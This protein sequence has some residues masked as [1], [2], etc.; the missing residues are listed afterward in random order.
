MNCSGG[1]TAKIIAR[2]ASRSPS[3]CAQK[4][5]HED[6]EERAPRQAGERQ[7]DAP[8]AEEMEVAG[9]RVTARRAQPRT[10]GKEERIGSR[11]DAK[12]A[13]PRKHAVGVD[14][15]ERERKVER[16]PQQHA[17]RY[18]RDAEPR[19]AAG[20]IRGR[21]QTSSA[22]PSDTECTHPTRNATSSR[23][24]PRSASK[25]LDELLRVPDDDRA[26]SKARRRSGAARVPNRAPLR[27]LRRKECRRRVPLLP[28]GGL[29]R[30]Y[31]PPAI[32]ALAMRGEFLTAYT[33]YQA[34]VSQG[35]L[36]AI[37]EWQTYICSAHR[38]GSRQRLG[39]RRRDRA[40]RSGDHGARRDRPQ[41]GSRLARDPSELSR[42]AENVLRR[43]R[44]RRRRAA[45]HRGRHDRPGRTRRQRSADKEYAA[46]ALQSPNFFGNVDTP[47]KRDARSNRRERHDSDRRRRR[48]ALARRA[49]AAVGVGRAD[50]RR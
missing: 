24:S 18:Q 50:R 12:R 31:A 27:S 49:R 29:V 3:S 16:R 43:A 13:E 41:Q 39:L 21:R 46:V 15:K 9:G 25:S 2:Q 33:P 34:E 45:V 35:Y 4:E 14:L 17:R 10:A 37:Y 44:R 48:S 7:R 28:R 6:Q 42:G 32:A 1:T 30:H 20:A 47:D 19:H 26:Q 40:R 22:Q 38:H 11:R 23:C 8:I 36:Q 5:Q